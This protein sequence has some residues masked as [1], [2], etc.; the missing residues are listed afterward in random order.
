MSMVDGS[1][2]LPCRMNTCDPNCV[3]AHMNKRLEVGGT[4]CTRIDVHVH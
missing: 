1:E 3:R 2:P 4:Q